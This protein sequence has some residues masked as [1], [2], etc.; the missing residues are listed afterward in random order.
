MGTFGTGSH[1]APAKRSAFSQWTHLS[2]LVT[3]REPDRKERSG[4][5][6]RGFTTLTCALMYFVGIARQER[7][8]VMTA[9]GGAD[10]TSLNPHPSRTA[11]G[12]G[13]Q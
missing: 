9:G 2:P 13:F 3:E 7:E 6:T 11:N 5:S 10:A 1:P 4:I 12:V 8:S